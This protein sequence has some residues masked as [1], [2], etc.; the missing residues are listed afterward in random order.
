MKI[1]ERTK[2]DRETELTE[3]VDKEIHEHCGCGEH[4]H[5]HTHSHHE[6]GKTCG[7]EGHHHAHSHQNKENED[8][9]ENPRNYAAWSVLS[10]CTPTLTFD[11]DKLGDRFGGAAAPVQPPVYKDSGQV[12]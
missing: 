4:H 11:Y 7:C 5:E 1:E 9:K 6:H 10:P 12:C 2:K 3:S 8:N